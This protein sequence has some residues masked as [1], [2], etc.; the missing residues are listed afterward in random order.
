[1]HRRPNS[2]GYFETDPKAGA[3]AVLVRSLTLRTDS[4]PHT[5]IMV[6]EDDV[7]KIPAAALATVDADA[8]SRALRLDG[9]ARVS[10]KMACR[11]TS[12]VK[13][14]SVV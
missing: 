10:L 11:E 12:E 5:G 9:S 2:S 13:T 14:D 3:I 6:Y 8:L 4:S 7:P 1:M